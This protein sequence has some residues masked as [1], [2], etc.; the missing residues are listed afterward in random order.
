MCATQWRNTVVLT[1]TSEIEN[2]DWPTKFATESEVFDSFKFFKITRF[3]QKHSHEHDAISN[4]NPHPS[5]Q[6]NTYQVNSP[7][8]FHIYVL[9]HLDKPPNLML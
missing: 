2:G 7:L 9:V 1:T 8:F 3:F 4:D 6:L 5:Y